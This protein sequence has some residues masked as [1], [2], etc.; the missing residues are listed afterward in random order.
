VRWRRGHRPSVKGAVAGGCSLVLPQ[1][2]R[3]FPWCC[4]KLNPGL[5]PYSCRTA[6]MPPA[7]GRG[8][9]GGR[10]L[11]FCGVE[12]GGTETTEVLRR[13]AGGELVGPAKQI[14][15]FTPTQADRRPSGAGRFGAAQARVLRDVDS[16]SSA[17]LTACI[18]RRGRAESRRSRLATPWLQ[19][20]SNTRRSSSR[21]HA[22]RF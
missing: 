2:R 5:F 8:D 19:K 17:K 22:C 20:Q 10:R 11:R 12:N 13:R 15:F 16:S 6:G 18:L 14:R 3:A 4:A 21:V 1:T 9:G 7:H